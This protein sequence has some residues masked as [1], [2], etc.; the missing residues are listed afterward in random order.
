MQESQANRA[1]RVEASNSNLS[2]PLVGSPFLAVGLLHFF[3]VV[4]WVG[5][6]SNLDCS[7]A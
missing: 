4:D 2:L 1:Q 7:V 3:V 6:M 5:R